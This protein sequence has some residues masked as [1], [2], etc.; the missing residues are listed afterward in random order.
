MLL[1]SVGVSLL[2]DQREAD[3]GGGEHV[4]MVPRFDAARHWPTSDELLSARGGN[5][6][7]E[8][9]R[10]E[11][12]FGRNLIFTSYANAPDVRV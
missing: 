7:R 5:R 4:S 12:L 10:I 3:S 11:F 1:D 9:Y 8:L 2:R 6:S